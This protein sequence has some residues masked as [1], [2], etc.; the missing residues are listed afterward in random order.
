MNAKTD[1]LKRRQESVFR[2][3]LLRS[4]VHWPHEASSR[5]LE[6]WATYVLIAIVEKGLKLDASLYTC[7]RILSVS[8]F[9]KTE[10]SSV[11]QVYQSKTDL[12]T[13]ASLRSLC[14][15]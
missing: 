3:F 7:L 12:S 5:G 6:K 1:A 15:I 2:L 10:I 13:F 4:I 9:E 11:L 14:N 8:I